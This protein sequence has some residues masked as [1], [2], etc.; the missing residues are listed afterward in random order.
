MAQTVSPP[1]QSMVAFLACASRAAHRFILRSEVNVF[2][3][4]GSCKMHFTIMD[5]KLAAIHR[6]TSA[7]GQAQFTWLLSYNT[8]AYGYQ[9]TAQEEAY[10]ALYSVLGAA[11]L[12]LLVLSGLAFKYRHL[13]PWFKPRPTSATAAS[14][15]NTY[16]G[17][18]PTIYHPHLGPRSL[19]DFSSS[20]E[21]IRQAPAHVRPSSLRGRPPF[22]SYMATVR[23]GEKMKTST[24]DQVRTCRPPKEE[25]ATA[26]EES[27]L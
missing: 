24:G 26:T 5:S 6:T 9:L 18:A 19:S 17:L 4:P 14:A 13:I 23:R 1:G 11:L 16:V 20:E 12:C 15:S 25:S 10:V 2:L 8:S 21:S 22:A 3:V 7:P 27:V